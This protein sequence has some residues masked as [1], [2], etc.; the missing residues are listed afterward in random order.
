MKVVFGFGGLGNQMSQ[1]SFY[2]AQKRLNRTVLFVNLVHNRFHGCVNIQD[3]FDL[4]DVI[5]LRGLL[6][7]CLVKLGNIFAKLRLIS[8]SPF[9]VSLP[10]SIYCE[11]LDYSFSPLAISRNNRSIILYY[12]GW[13]SP[14]YHHNIKGQVANSF[15]L[16]KSNCTAETTA[17]INELTDDSYES[18]GI[19]VR[20]GDYTTV[21]KHSFGDILTPDYYTNAVYHMLQHVAKPKFFLFSNEPSKALDYLRLNVDIRLSVITRSINAPSWEDMLLMSICKHLI[22]ANSTFSWWGAYLNN[23]ANR[24]I[25]CPPKF[26]LNHRSGEVYPVEWT[27]IQ[28]TQGT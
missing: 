27:R 6:A 18:I 26:S 22:I 11:S 3:V 21:A 16:H 28:S 8:S 13:H 23:D 4:K 9:C 15:R 1:Y 20:L 17:Y 14:L 2:L 10:F 12:G 19:H 5:T 24:V 7:L 25:I